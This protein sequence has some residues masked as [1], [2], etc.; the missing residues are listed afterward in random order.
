MTPDRT[1]PS[2]RQHEPVLQV[3][4]VVMR[5]GGLLALDGIDLT[6]AHGERLVILGPNGAGKSTLFNV[7]AGDLVPTSG[8]VTIKGQDCTTMPS[9]GRPSL[10]VARTYQKARS[11]PGLTVEDNLYLAVVGKEGRH[12]SL[13]LV[14]RSLGDRI[15]HALKSVWLADKRNALVSGLSHGEKRQLEVGM[16]V[17][18]DPDVMLLDEP[19]SGLSRGERER[20]IELLQQLGADT[21]LL[22]IEHDMD[23]AFQV[24]ERIFVMADGKPVAMGTPDE[25][26]ANERV[27][28]IYLGNEA[29]A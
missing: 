3:S 10:G 1:P 18:T 4:S 25:I 14:D 8:T 15:G 11:F 9:R 20:L 19:A 28:D 22:L 2:T 16:A 24:A 21:T 7:I 13:S 17:I 23:V 12:R 26:R 6:V 29:A 5:F 27:H